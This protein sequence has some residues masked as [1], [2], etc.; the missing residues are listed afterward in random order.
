MLTLAWIEPALACADLALGAALVSRFGLDGAIA[1][2]P[3]VFALYAVALHGAARRVLPVTYEYRRLAMVAGL[4]VALGVIGF[5]G[6]TGGHGVNLALRFAVVA[7]FPAL[8]AL[9]VFRADDEREAM[10]AL[11][12]RLRGGSGW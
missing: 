10:R 9:S 12:A 11:W 3:I 2:T 5:R 4:A 8:V 7:A 1:T 6:V